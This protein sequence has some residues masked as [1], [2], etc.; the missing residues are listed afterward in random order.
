MLAP[1]PR[2]GRAYL[3]AVALVVAGN[4]R[5]GVL[6]GDRL[7]T[8]GLDGDVE[9]PA[10]ASQLARRLAQELLVAHRQLEVIPM[11]LVSSL[12]NLRAVGPDA[13]LPADERL[14]ALARDRER[15][16]AERPRV[17]AVRVDP[18][19]HDVPPVADQE[20]D[21]RPRKQG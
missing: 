20:D 16:L 14:A 7:Q 12:H 13:R 10:D 8:L 21:P 6:A 15:A 19:I 17:G 5:V 1:C 2:P 9:R 3:L 18:R 11:R 4:A